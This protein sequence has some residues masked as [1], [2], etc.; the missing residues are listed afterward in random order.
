MATAKLFNFKLISWL[1]LYALMV[2]APFF[3]MLIHP[4]RARSFWYE[5]SIGFGFVGLAIMGVQ[6]ILTARFRGL[7]AVV[8]MDS[9]LQFHRQMGLIAFTFVLA[10]PIILLLYNPA[11]L[12]FLDPK[13]NFL[14]A[15]F[16]ISSL[17]ALFLVA[18][19]PLFRKSLKISYQW[20]RLTH[21]IFASI[22]LIV[23]LAHIIMVGR[24]VS[25]LWQQSLWIVLIGTSLYL[26]THTRVVKPLLATRRPWKVKSVVTEKSDVWTI[27]LEA[28]KHGGLKF[29]PGQCV[30]M[31]LG[32]KPFSLE[33]HP[34]TIASSAESNKELA[35]TIKAL[36]DFTRS[37]GQIE[38]GTNA[39]LEG[40]YGKFTYDPDSSAPAA[41]IVGGIGVT[42]AMSNLRTMKDREDK[43]ELLLIYGNV[44]Q[45]SILFKD[46]L[47]K[48][49]QSLNLK[50]V[51]VLDNSPEESA[52][53][54]GP[55]NQ[56]LLKKHLGEK[57]SPQRFHYY[58]C[59]P[60]PMMDSVELALLKMEV[61]ADRINTERFNIV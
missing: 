37:I 25:S 39:L 51:H 4:P 6:F 55:I 30:W 17:V 57:K 43:R 42:T 5:L 31:T 56:S 15:V 21:G 20:W 18:L 22:V 13:V 19:L 40:P 34:F 53:E 46:E 23:G 24:Y 16:L 52:Y 11:T 49:Q 36:G 47:E 33:Q 41:F 35:I 38:P 1:L 2:L 3:L 28:H 10:H 50:V 27:F 26:L 54:Q 45:D 7:S 48:L 8:G 58:I 60:E 59:G 61:P 44:D 14:R 9:M 32:A 12:S 29:L